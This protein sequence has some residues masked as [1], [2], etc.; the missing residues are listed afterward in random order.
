MENSYTIKEILEQ[1]FSEANG[2]LVEIKEEVRKTN[3]RVT[4][5]EHHRSYLWGAYSVI[6]IVSGFLLV[7]IW[8]ALENRVREWMREELSIHF[9]A[10]E[11]NKDSR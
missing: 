2:H 9:S 4:K 8:G 7:L 11:Q 3:G 1:R 5:L 10:L 6:V